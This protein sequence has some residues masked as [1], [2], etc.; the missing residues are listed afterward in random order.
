MRQELS[1][2]DLGRVWSEVKVDLCVLCSS[3]LVADGMKPK[4]EE[5]LR[6]YCQPK[7]PVSGFIAL[8]KFHN[9][10]HGGRRSAGG[11]GGFR[12]PKYLGRNNDTG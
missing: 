12:P 11:H 3:P 9:N 8:E 6:S 4:M 7:W 5:T 1:V 2:L 10:I